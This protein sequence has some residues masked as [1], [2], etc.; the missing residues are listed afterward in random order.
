M[1]DKSGIA[2]A[3]QFIEQV[4]NAIEG[5]AADPYT[6]LDDK[7]VVWI[8]G[9]TPISGTYRGLNHV[10]HVL[11]S[12]A[13]KCVSHMRMEAKEFIGSGHR[14]AALVVVTGTTPA[15]EVY[16]E[17]KSTCGFVFEVQGGKITEIRAFLDT[18]Q[19]E[20]LLFDNEYVPSGRLA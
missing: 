14:F 1:I 20:T 12:T 17:E 18:T 9:T 4:N 3:E 7:V 6:L 13:A 2:I 8:L 15:G 10:K 5:G 11:V 16:N 19:I